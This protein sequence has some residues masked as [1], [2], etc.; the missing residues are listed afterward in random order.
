MSRD[1][2]VLCQQARIQVSYLS[3]SLF[4][5]Q[6]MLGAQAGVSLNHST[7]ELWHA[8][9]LLCLTLHFL[10]DEALEQSLIHKTRL[11]PSNGQDV[12]A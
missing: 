2:D 12:V 1:I 4:S 5:S 10:A 8:F 9:R 3:G 11:T 6:C 7:I